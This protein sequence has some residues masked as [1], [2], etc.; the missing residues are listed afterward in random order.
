MLVEKDATR[1][2][3]ERNP[4]F[5]MVDSEGNQLPYI[6]RIVVNVV[7]DR[8]SI[9]GSIIAGD[10]DFAGFHTDTTSIP[11]YQQ[12]AEQGSY[13][14]T[15]WQNIFSAVVLWPNYCYADPAVATALA[16]KDFRVAMQ[17]TVDRERINQEVMF[18]LAR[19]V[20]H[21]P[22]PETNMLFDP[23]F[24]T[25][26]SEYDPDQ[27]QTLLDGIDITDKDGD[28]WRDAPDGSPIT[29][30][31]PYGEHTHPR[32]WSALLGFRYLVGERLYPGAVL[33]PGSTAGDS[34]RLAAADDV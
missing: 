24:E 7:N 29:M 6:D 14:M 19:T 23:E 16:Q 2:V 13:N 8:E 18:G 15:L 11:L 10:I 12:Y 22:K 26:Y 34:G 3:Y 30:V 1:S 33:L 4:Y 28:D 5:W 25:L 9:D 32:R 31:I 27:A 20:R 21:A 17:L